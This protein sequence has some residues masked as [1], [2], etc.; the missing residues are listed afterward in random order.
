MLK[1]IIILYVNI[2]IK[3]Y[4]R[5]NAYMQIMCY[6]KYDYGTKYNGPRLCTTDDTLVSLMLNLSWCRLLA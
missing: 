2:E 1:F 5:Y 3:S 4:I 6:N